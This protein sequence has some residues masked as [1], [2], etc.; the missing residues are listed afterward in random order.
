[1]AREDK[2]FVLKDGLEVLRE[3]RD[4]S[5]K[6]FI[7]NAVEE[8]LLNVDSYQEKTLRQHLPE[9]YSWIINV[10]KRYNKGYKWGKPWE[11]AD[12]VEIR[13]NEKI[14]LFEKFINELEEK[15]KLKR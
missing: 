7:C 2:L 15:W 14:K 1:M 12:G 6:R 5:T 9:F 11:N 3:A 8:A 13:R 10:G 4:G